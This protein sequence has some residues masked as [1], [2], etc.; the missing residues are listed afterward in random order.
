MAGPILLYV[1][2]YVSRIW[3]HGTHLCDNDSVSSIPTTLCG[4]S[5]LV[6]VCLDDF[7]KRGNLHVRLQRVLVPNL[8]FRPFCGDDSGL[9]WIHGVRLCG[10]DDP[11]RLFGRLIIAL[12]C[13]V[14]V[15]LLRVSFQCLC[16]RIDHCLMHS[17]MIH[18]TCA[19]FSCATAS[20]TNPSLI[21]SVVSPDNI[22]MLGE[23]I[24]PRENSVDQQAADQHRGRRTGH[25]SDTS[26]EPTIALLAVSAATTPSLSSLLGAILKY[27]PCPSDMNSPLCSNGK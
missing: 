22:G 2:F 24:G 14:Y 1:W 21:A 4:E 8:G 26:D 18:G 19:R 10:H 7:W 27:H 3:H 23:N 9:L 25:S 13:S 20:H 16:Q 12:V 15:P 6:V 5:S 11:V 17:F